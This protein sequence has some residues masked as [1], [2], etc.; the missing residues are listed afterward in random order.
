MFNAFSLDRQQQAAFSR[1]ELE[2]RSIRLQRTSSCKRN[3]LSAGYKSRVHRF[4]LDMLTDPIKIRPTEGKAGGKEVVGTGFRVGGYRSEKERVQGE[5]SRHSG[6]DLEPSAKPVLRQRVLEKEIHPRMYFKHRT[7]LERICHIT[8]FPNELKPERSKSEEK[9]SN[10]SL[11][12]SQIHTKSTLLAKVFPS[13]HRK[14]HFKA[15]CSI[16]A[17][18]PHSSLLSPD[19]SGSRNSPAP[20]PLRGNGSLREEDTPYIAREV[21]KDCEVVTQ[22]HSRDFLR[23]KSGKFGGNQAE[24]EGKPAS[25]GLRAKSAHQL[26]VYGC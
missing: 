26:A 4:M 11:E 12:Q 19:I 5:A 2:D 7:E 20:P 17:K 18:L 25:K 24:K 9:L 16:M 10:R 13:L 6:L 3:R 1:K 23:A 21:L 15:V 14:T 22:H 8:D